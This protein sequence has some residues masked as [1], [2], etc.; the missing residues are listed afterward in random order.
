MLRDPN[1]LRLSLG[2]MIYGALQLVVGSLL[3]VFLT[4]SLGRDLIVAGLLLSVSQAGAVIGRVGWGFVAD[5][6]GALRG[7]LIGIGAGMAL[8]CF[9]AGLLTPATPNWLVGLVAFGLGA[10]TSGWNGVFLTCLIRAVPVEKA[11]F[12]A[13]GSL[14]F[15]YSGIMIGPPLFGVMAFFSSFS[16]AFFASAVLALVGAYLC[17]PVARAARPFAP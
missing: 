10:T 2:S 1:L 11:G 7:V 12:A 9:L 16:V 13:S 14:L 5:R 15:S 3:V 6:L 4:A 8:M 17:R